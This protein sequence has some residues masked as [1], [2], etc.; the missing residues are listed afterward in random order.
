MAALAQVELGCRVTSSP[1]DENLRWFLTDP[2]ARVLRRQ[3]EPALA[4]GAFQRALSL[5]DQALAALPTSAG[6]ARPGPR[7]CGN[8]G[9]GLNRTISPTAAPGR[10]GRPGW[11]AEDRRPA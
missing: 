2:D 3:I 4:V 10:S 1:A 7:G 6:R 8:S 9:S 5:L 11:P